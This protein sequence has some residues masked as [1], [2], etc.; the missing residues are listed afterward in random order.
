[1]PRAVRIDSRSEGGLAIFLETRGRLAA[2]QRAMALAIANGDRG[3]P[4]VSRR[5]QDQIW[6]WRWRW[7]MF[8]RGGVE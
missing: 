5:G 2:R 3:S 4:A 8:N 1:M 7:V 6:R